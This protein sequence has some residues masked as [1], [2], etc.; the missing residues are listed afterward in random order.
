M[1]IQMSVSQAEQILNVKRTDPI[2]QIKI[3]HR[4]LSKKYHPDRV[5]GSS[6]NQKK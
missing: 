4:E 1:N 3:Q 2:Q 5:G 6:E